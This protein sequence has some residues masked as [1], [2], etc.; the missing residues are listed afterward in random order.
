MYLDIRELGVNKMY[1]VYKI[2]IKCIQGTTLY[3]LFI[4]KL[5][6]SIK[7]MTDFLFPTHLKYSCL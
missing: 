5:V 2:K 6:L 1:G 7:K 4:I 3:N